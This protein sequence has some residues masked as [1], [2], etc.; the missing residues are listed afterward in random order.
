MDNDW[1]TLFS[2]SQTTGQ[3]NTKLDNHGDWNTHNT[4]CVY[5][6]NNKNNKN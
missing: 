5:I 6:N 2:L 1:T 4:R 3:N